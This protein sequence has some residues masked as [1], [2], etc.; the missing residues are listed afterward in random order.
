MDQ[1]EHLVETLLDDVG[2]QFPGDMPDLPRARARQLHRLL[3]IHE[4]GE[5]HTKLLLRPLGFGKGNRQAP[6]EIVRNRG[7]PKGEDRKM[8]EFAVAID[9][10][11]GST[12]TALDHCDAHFLLILSED[13]PGRRKGFEHQFLNSVTRPLDRLPDVLGHR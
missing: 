3:R 6:H 4:L 13:R 1:A 12:S 10:K 7:S 11:V 5:R 2:N 9:C 8:S